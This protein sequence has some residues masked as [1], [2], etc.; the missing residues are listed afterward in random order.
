MPFFANSEALDG[1]MK[2]LFRR[3]LADPSALRELARSGMLFRLDITDPRALV[4][5]NGKV[6]PPVF[7]YG[8]AADRVDLA[9]HTPADVLH[10][11]LLKQVRLR[12]AFFGGKMK[13]DGSIL[14]ARRLENLFHCLQD[15]YPGV[16]RDAG[17]QPDPTRA[18]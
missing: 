12:D 16:L 15:L 18:T 4:T 11:V 9:I 2:E 5:V 17:M 8:Q 13:I 10:Q 1:I 6:Q 3:V 7:T 14:R